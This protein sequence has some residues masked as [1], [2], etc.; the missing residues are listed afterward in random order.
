MLT[1][2]NHLRKHYP[3]KSSIKY[4]GDAVFEMDVV[5]GGYL[6]FKKKN[7]KDYFRFQFSCEFLIDVNEWTIEKC[8][9]IIPCST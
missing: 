9:K 6:V 3:G 5:N 4:L 2:K 1:W 8:G 7:C